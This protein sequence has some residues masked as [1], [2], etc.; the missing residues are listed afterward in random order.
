MFYSLL[1]K[2][3]PAQGGLLNCAVFGLM[4]WITFM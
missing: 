2:Q 1:D 3:K 4:G